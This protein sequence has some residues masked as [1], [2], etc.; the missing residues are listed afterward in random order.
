MDLGSRSPDPVFHGDRL[1]VLAAQQ[2]PAAARECST[3]WLGTES[4]SIRSLSISRREWP[5]SQEK[6]YLVVAAYIA[7]ILV[8][9]AVMLIIAVNVLTPHTT[10]GG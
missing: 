5:V 10:H 1:V 7:G 9:I 8:L 4:L 2:T 6:N 3:L